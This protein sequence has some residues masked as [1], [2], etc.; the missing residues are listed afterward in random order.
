MKKKQEPCL[1]PEIETMSK[2]LM[3]RTD[4]NIAQIPIVLACQKRLVDAE[5]KPVTIWPI[6]ISD[7]EKIT[8]TGSPKYG[9]PYG[10]QVD[11]FMASTALFYQ[12]NALQNNTIYFPAHQL[13]R[14]AGKEP[15][16]DEYRRCF[17]AL[18]TYANFSIETEE[19]LSANGKSLLTG[20][21]E[22][23]IKYFQE[24][25][26]VG[27]A[28][29]GRK[30]TDSQEYDGLCKLVLTDWCFNNLRS[31]KFSTLL[32]YSFMMSLKTPLTKQLY[33]FLDYWRNEEL[34]KTAV[35]RQVTIRKELIEVG[36]RLTLAVRFPSQV[37]QQLTESHKELMKNGYLEKIV[38]VTEKKQLKY[39]DYTISPFTQAENELVN[40]LV[41]RGVSLSMARELVRTTE[42]SKTHNAII[43]YDLKKKKKH[44]N[45]GYLVTILRDAAPDSLQQ[46]VS[47]ELAVQTDTI[48]RENKDHKLMFEYARIGEEQAKEKMAAMSPE[49]LAALKA[50][51]EKNLDKFE[52]NPEMRDTAIERHMCLIMIEE[53]NMPPF[54]EWVLTQQA[55]NLKHIN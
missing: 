25:R 12:K 46:D 45:A 24:F 14:I 29:R 47:S 4:I 6:D 34:A 31:E 53:L 17:E 41:Q 15:G 1:F 26:V 39:V 28:R 44:L 38:Y 13:I 48:R 33:R 55:R 27:I 8:L 37:K 18:R 5:G 11:Y 10:S 7:T 36:K 9:L 20:R 23:H 16:G 19:L 40:K 54:E 32:N 51:A 3:I 2:D 30:L 49:A 42:N 22:R 50:R 21:E 35:K 43:Y 52:R